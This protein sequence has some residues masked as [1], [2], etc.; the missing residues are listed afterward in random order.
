MTTDSLAAALAELQTQLPPITK[1]LT[2]K[3]ETRGGSSYKYT[4][5]DLAQISREV[6][7][8][9]GK[10]GLSFTSRP[11]LRADGR[12]V[13][14]YK[15]LHVSGEHESGEY[16]LLDKGTP[17]EV[18]SAITYARRYCL[19]AV[20]GVAPEDDDHDAVQAER[21]A[22]REAKKKAAPKNGVTAQ[23]NLRMQKLF[24]ELGMTD[25]DAKLGY[26]REVVGRE[27][28]SATE[29]TGVEADKVIARLESWAAQEQP[30]ADGAA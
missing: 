23:Q 14:S 3:V 15:L 22:Q 26:A 20:T 27:L 6:L 9:L 17:Q 2:A 4:Y 25:R 19:C 28:G 11:T 29:L 21:A 16:P 24:K 13:L 5:A 1:D 18:G 8:L 12:F 7:P 30:P 10:L